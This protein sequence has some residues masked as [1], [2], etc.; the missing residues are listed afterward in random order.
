MSYHHIEQ[1]IISW[2]SSNR[3][4]KS[5]Y[6]ISIGTRHTDPTIKK[7]CARLIQK[8]VLEKTV[9]PNKGGWTHYR[10]RAEVS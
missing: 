9:Q 8:G 5:A 2:L 6:R 7:Y 10:I 1:E 4:Y 3:G